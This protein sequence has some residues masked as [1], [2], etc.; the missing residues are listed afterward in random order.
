MMG[1]HMIVL[2]VALDAELVGAAV[3]DYLSAV[4]VL[5]A[6][7]LF[8]AALNGPDTLTL[9]AL[10]RVAQHYGLDLHVTIKPRTAT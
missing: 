9:D 6:S 5:H 1:H 2:H 4:A 10:Y 3:C 8:A 7:D